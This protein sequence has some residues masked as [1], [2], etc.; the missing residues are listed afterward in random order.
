MAIMTFGPQ[1]KLGLRIC[2]SRL[3]AI[4][5]GFICF[6]FKFIMVLR[7]MNAITKIAGKRHEFRVQIPTRGQVLHSTM[8]QSKKFT[9]SYMFA[10]Y[11]T[12]AVIAILLVLIVMVHPF[13]ATPPSAPPPSTS[14]TSKITT[15]N[16]TP[17]GIQTGQTTQMTTSTMTSTSKTT[18]T[19]PATSASTTTSTNTAATV[20]VGT[21]QTNTAVSSTTSMT[22]TRPIQGVP[23]FPF[24]IVLVAGIS[25]AAMLV[26]RNKSL[27][28]RN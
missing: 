25:M 10:S 23:E 5:S 7:C 14:S 24:G 1:W 19:T 17:G 12:I 16:T 4:D 26:I 18:S 9:R 28:K 6:G 8:S 11:V 13:G 3:V 22:T 15:T 27:G 20:V 21:T 2:C